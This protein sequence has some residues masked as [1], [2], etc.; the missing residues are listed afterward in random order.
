MTNLLITN[1]SSYRRLKKIGEGSFGKVFLVKNVSNNE[2]VVAKEIKLDHLAESTVIQLYAEVKIL[3]RIKHDNILRM[4]EAYRTKSN[5]LVLILE[6]ASNADLSC[7]IT[8]TEGQYIDMNQ[9]ELWIL[10]LCMGIKCIH[11]HRIIH[12]DLKPQNILL[13][14]HNNIKLGDFGLAIDLQANLAYSN[15]IEGTPINL[16]PEVCIKQEFSY[17]SDI[18]SLGLIIYEICALKHPFNN[19][20]CTNLFYSICNNIIDPLPDIYNEELK[21]FVMFLLDKDPEKRP[22]VD[23]IFESPFIQSLIYKYKDRLSHTIQEKCTNYIQL[24]YIDIKS[25]FKGMKTYR[26]SEYKNPFLLADSIKY[27]GQ[28]EYKKSEFEFEQTS[29]NSLNQINESPLNKNIANNY[30]NNGAFI[31]YDMQSDK[32]RSYEK[33]VV[34]NSVDDAEEPLSLQ[35]IKTIN[36]QNNDLLLSRE[37]LNVSSNK[38]MALE[39]KLD[40][41]NIDKTIIK[42]EHYEVCNN[43]KNINVIPNRWINHNR[44]LINDL[45]NTKVLLKLPKLKINHINWLKNSDYKFQNINNY[46]DKIVDRLSS[47]RIR[48]PNIETSLTNDQK[49]SFKKNYKKLK[50]KIPFQ[51]ST[52][53]KHSLKPNEKRKK[54]ILSLNINELTSKIKLKT[55]KSHLKLFAKK[56]KTACRKGNSL[57][58]VSNA[59][60]ID[61]PKIYSNRVLQINQCSSVY[62]KNSCLQ[63]LYSR[64]KNNPTRN[65]HKNVSDYKMKK[66]QEVNNIHEQDKKL[67]NA[68]KNSNL[69]SNIFRHEPSKCTRRLKF[70]NDQIK[71]SSV[72]V[73]ASNK[74]SQGNINND[75]HISN[76]PRIQKFSFKNKSI[77]CNS[78]KLMKNSNNTITTSSIN[79]S[80][81]RIIQSINS[82]LKYKEKHA[83]IQYDKSP[84]EIRNIFR[85]LVHYY[86]KDIINNIK[87]NDNEL[88]KLL[89]K[90]S[91]EQFDIISKTSRHN[92]TFKA[93]YS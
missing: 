72:N 45:L 73:I 17:K 13:D 14:Q 66:N 62:T 52:S 25:E 1:S 90:H 24:D 46:N 35:Q 51:D 26:F 74:L 81:A 43:N 54:A 49:T 40:V 69:T 8:N 4:I 88:K 9:I 3:E 38:S 50:Y 22:T 59:Y 78:L 11:D 53:F 31:N 16:A 37:D 86:G 33:L 32:S 87:Y 67:Y 92:R 47:R 48:Q 44:R 18:W 23:Q 2:E 83:Q 91:D 61:R 58:P 20:N 77:L 79:S 12:R 41:K 55:R 28:Q 42:A 19:A 89:D 60:F 56:S 30:E 63:S 36:K 65:I 80:R 68:L 27:I 21:S 76:S 15:K 10:Q 64:N 84:E 39:N 5:K 7:F 82:L 29:L 93:K 6:H 85:N 70:R 34:N 57:P 75:N 71:K